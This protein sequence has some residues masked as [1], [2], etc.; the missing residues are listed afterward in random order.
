MVLVFSLF[1]LP[2]FFCFFF[3]CIVFLIFG[4]CVFFFFFFF[5][6]SGRLGLMDIIIQGANL[7][8]KYLKLE[9]SFLCKHDW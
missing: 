8:R 1:I 3:S 7:Q 5:H 4:F 9:K 2:F 6:G